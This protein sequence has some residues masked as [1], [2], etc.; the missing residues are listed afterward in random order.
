MR[1]SL[2]VLCLSFLLVDVLAAK[3][4]NEWKIM[5][6]HKVKEVITTPHVYKADPPAEFTWGNKNGV[7]YLSKTLNQHIPQYCGSCWAHGAVSALADRIKIA[8]NGQSPDIDL[9][10]QYIL[11]CGGD[12]AGSCY[13]GDAG[14]TYEFIHQ[15][16]FIPYD[17][18]IPYSAC[19]S[20]SDEGFCAQADWTCSAINTCRTCNT[21]TESGGKCVALNHFPNA[22]ISQYGT[23]SGEKDMMNEIISHG[24]I[25]CGIDAEGIVNYAGGIANVPGPSSIN[26]VVSVVGWGVD[27]PTSTPYWI[28]RNSWGQTYGELGYFRLVRGQNQ[29]Q[30]ESSCNWAKPGSWTEVNYPCFE[31]GSNC[32]GKA[33]R[34]FSTDS[35]MKLS[36]RTKK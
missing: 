22:T 26:H 14:G 31:D 27:T 20:D 15:T 8:R 10:I 13:G 3:R 35:S 4:F 19:S 1:F 30:I 34:G 21:F 32:Q 29:L 23:V 24:P 12:V 18:C 5:P 33:D 2:A 9:S 36:K 16:G 11:N 25:A 7:G 17:T 28:I 6:G